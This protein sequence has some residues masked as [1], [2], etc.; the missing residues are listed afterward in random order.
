[1]RNRSL[2]QFYTKIER[3]IQLAVAYFGRPWLEQVIRQS[4]LKPL[5]T[6]GSNFKPSTTLQRDWVD[7]FGNV[8]TLYHR[9]TLVRWNLA[10]FEQLS[11]DIYRNESLSFIAQ[12]SKMACVG[13][14]DNSWMVV[15]LGSDNYWRTYHCHDGQI[16]VCS[17]FAAGLRI[18]RRFI[19][20]QLE[21]TTFKKLGTRSA[22]AA[23]HSYQWTIVGL[24][25]DQQGQQF[26]Q[27]H[28]QLRSLL[29]NGH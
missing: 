22:N 8:L 9:R 16:H 23:I 6:F 25:L 10:Q 13:I 15:L 11:T 26:V 1:M 2:E 28:Q 5:K 19:E 29:G 24:P 21:P 7:E 12:R 14:C 18:L 17:P 3:Q 20:Y 4:R 27:S